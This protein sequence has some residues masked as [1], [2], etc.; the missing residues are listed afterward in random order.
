MLIVQKYGGTSV[1]DREKLLTA[2]EEMAQAP[3]KIFMTF[4]NADL[5]F[6]DAVFGPDPQPL[7]E[8]LAERGL[9]PT[10]ICESAGTQTVDAATMSRLYA[11]ALK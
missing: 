11:A 8:L 7:M 4:S 10:V 1:A 5:T 2:A 9:C 3:D 6:E